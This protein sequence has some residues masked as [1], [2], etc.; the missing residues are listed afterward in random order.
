ML[1]KEDKYFL[2]NI[3]HTL[4]RNTQGVKD[5]NGYHSCEVKFKFDKEAELRLVRLEQLF[6]EELGFA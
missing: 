4:N 1:T 3:L 2:A 5:V 6:R